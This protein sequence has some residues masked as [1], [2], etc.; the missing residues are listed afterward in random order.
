MP[1]TTLSSTNNPKVKYIVRLQRDRR[2]RHKEG[3]F[4]AEGLRWL[5][6]VLAMG[7]AVSE[8]YVD[9]ALLAETTTESAELLAQIDAPIY[10]VTPQV[11]QHISGLETPAGIVIVLPLAT[12]RLAPTPSLLLIGDCIQNPG[13]LGT[14]LRTAAA[15]G[16]DGILLTPGCVDLFNPKVVRAAMGAHLRLA[17]R[18]A[19]W[20]E[21][22]ALTA[23]MQVFCADAG[24][25]RLYSAVDWTAATALIVGN[26]ANGLSAKARALGSSLSIP[27]ANAT[28]S[29]NAAMAAGIMLFE[30]DRQRRLVG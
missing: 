28:E 25:D 17:A 24:G 3:R 20:A 27:M 21:I 13:N 4:V 11:M 16:A 23:G 12:V 30:A 9:Q 5:R 14:L 7:Q 19:D 26:E 2:F 18:V 8:L 15:A 1:E 10:A 6:D 29:L 22:G